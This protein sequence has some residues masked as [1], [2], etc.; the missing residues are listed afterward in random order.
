MYFF[1]PFSRLK[2]DSDHELDGQGQLLVAMLMLGVYHGGADVFG[3]LIHPESV[4][5]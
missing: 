5:E 4:R 3:L 1:L 2:S